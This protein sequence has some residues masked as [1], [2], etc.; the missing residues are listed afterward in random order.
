M[1]VP[2]S[3]AHKR[4][5]TIRQKANDGGRAMESETLP[6]DSMSQRGA[7]FEAAGPRV[8]QT[9]AFLSPCILNCYNKIGKAFK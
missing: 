3:D 1:V 9:N 2:Q 8:F 6:L 4:L 7:C 5:G